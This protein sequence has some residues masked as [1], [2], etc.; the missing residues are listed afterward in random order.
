MTDPLK[1]RCVCRR[2]AVNYIFL[3][4]GNGGQL[5]SSLTW[6]IYMQF[7]FRNWFG[8][9]HSPSLFIHR[10][11]SLTINKYMV[12]YATL[13]HR[14]LQLY[15]RNW[16]KLLTCDGLHVFSYERQR[17]IPKIIHSI[18]RYK[19]NKLCV[20]PCQQQQKQQNIKKKKHN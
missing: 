19:F 10:F 6:K 13:L 2:H 7:K 14:L 11:P 17:Y 18:I 16:F 9:Q 20:C 15:S 1:K 12:T 8:L 5:Q 3:P 4:G